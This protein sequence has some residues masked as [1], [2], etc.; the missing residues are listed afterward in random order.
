MEDKKNILII[1]LK[2]VAILF[3]AYLLIVNAKLLIDTIEA[4]ILKNMPQ[5]TTNITDN[6]YDKFWEK[7]INWFKAPPVVEPIVP[8]MVFN[9]IVTLAGIIEI[10]I[11]FTKKKLNKYVIWVTLVLVIISLFLPI[12]SISDPYELQNSIHYIYYSIEDLFIYR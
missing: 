2:I 3:L 7:G 1:S 10:I 11:S 9:I 4:K 12:E 5:N 8:S 6:N